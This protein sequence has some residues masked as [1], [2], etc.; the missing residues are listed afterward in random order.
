MQVGQ[1]DRFDCF[2]M[3]LQTFYDSPNVLSF[4]HLVSIAGLYNNPV[5]FYHVSYTHELPNKQ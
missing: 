5:E 2:I 1:I 4:Q 3:D